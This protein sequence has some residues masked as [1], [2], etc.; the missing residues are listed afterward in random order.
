MDTVFRSLAFAFRNLAHPRILWL[1]IWPVVVA[2]VLWG[3]VLI[4]FWAR[5]VVWLGEKM[6]EWIAT[7]TFFVTWDASDV[8]IVTAKVFLILMLVVM[9][10]WPLIGLV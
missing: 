10:Y 4:A 6:N 3:G 8:A 7:A 2:L 1:M 9:F 5:L